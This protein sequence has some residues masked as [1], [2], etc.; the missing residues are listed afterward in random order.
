MSLQN[1]RLWLPV[2]VAVAC[3]GAKLEVASLQRRH[4]W[5][6]MVIADRLADVELVDLRAAYFIS[7]DEKR[8]A[9]NPHST[10]RQEILKSC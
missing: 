3:H 9:C 2:T 10:V 4:P 8:P 5:A 7:A 1:F 6:A